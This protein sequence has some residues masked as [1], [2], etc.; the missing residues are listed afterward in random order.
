MSKT[1]ERVIQENR[2]DILQRWHERG[3][4]LFAEKMSA[5]TPV[6]EALADGMGMIL[7][8]FGDGGETCREGVNRL[9]RILAVHPFRPSRSM[10]LFRELQTILF[11]SASPGADH[12]LCRE[13][14]GQITFD[15]F[16]SFMEHRE[17]IYKLKV[18]ESRSQMHMLLRRAGT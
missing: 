16:D 11:E 17:L 5:G 9:A 3:L 7:D 6:G 14:I 1:W 18:E 8:G 12:E 13:R 2:K 10:S 15:A 4:G